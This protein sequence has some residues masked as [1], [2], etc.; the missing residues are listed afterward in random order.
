MR[1]IRLLLL[2][3][4]V[5]YLIASLFHVGVVIAGYRHREAFIAESIIAA[6][7]FL[8]LVVGWMRPSWTRIAA[9]WAQS[10]ALLL[11][12]VGLFVIIMGVGPRTVP[13]VVYHVAIVAVLIHGLVLASRPHSDHP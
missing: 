10:F 2:G 3:E 5:S 9:L 8:G 12:F 1:Q 11:T 13:D 6:V 7:L 4:A